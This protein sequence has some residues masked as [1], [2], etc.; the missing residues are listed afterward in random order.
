MA[1]GPAAGPG[2]EE[3]PAEGPGPEKDGPGPE[4]DGP[5]PEND[6]PGPENDGPG[7]ENDGPGP[8][9]DGPGPEKVGPG[10]ALAFAGVKLIVC[11]DGFVVPLVEEIVMLSIDLIPPED[12]VDGPGPEENDPPFAGVI[13]YDELAFAGTIVTLFIECI[14]P[15]GP[16]EAPGPEE[17]PGFADVIVTDDM[18][19]APPAAGDEF[20]LVRL[21]DAIE[22]IA[23][24]PDDAAAGAAADALA[25][26]EVGGDRSA[27]MASNSSILQKKKI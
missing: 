7:P 9:N 2:P 26:P 23:P 1:P 8:E 3:K 22:C 11:P 10:P 17:K 6:G 18:E 14:P 21:T 25:E 13:E 27:N 12:V 24:G 5:G 16:E 15:P 19:W 4:N 20:A